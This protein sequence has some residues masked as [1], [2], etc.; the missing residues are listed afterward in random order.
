[1]DVDP[2]Y[3]IPTTT[4]TTSPDAKDTRSQEVSTTVDILSVATQTVA[5]DIRRLTGDV[6]SVKN[7]IDA[8]QQECAKLKSSVGEQHTYMHGL[9]PNQESLNTDLASI[10]HMFE[11]SR[12]ASLDGTILWKIENFRE[13]LGK[14][15]SSSDSIG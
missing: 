2:S 12:S 1:M 8:V 10:Q 4:A 5:Q 6:T 15:S 7:G 14:L 11:E 9:Q 13:K 3:A